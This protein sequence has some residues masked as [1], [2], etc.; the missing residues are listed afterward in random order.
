MSARFSDS[1]KLAPIRNERLNSGT[2]QGAPCD[3][4]D[5]IVEAAITHLKNGMN[6]VLQKDS[7]SQVDQ[8][9]AAARFTFTRL[10]HIRGFL[11]S[12]RDD[13]IHTFEHTP[14]KD[15]GNGAGMCPDSCSIVDQSHA[16]H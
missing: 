7:S 1:L 12:S 11:S 2:L 9:Q 13:H 8:P 5:E 3:R 16:N 14:L 10:E 4:G 15:T 6:L